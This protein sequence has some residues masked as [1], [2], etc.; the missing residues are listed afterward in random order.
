MSTVFLLGFNFL[1]GCNSSEDYLGG[2]KISEGKIV[3]TLSYPQFAD[4]NIF[5]SMFPSEMNFK[6]KDNNTRN[7]LKTKMAIFSTSLL[8]NNKEKKAT[9]LVKIA[10]KYSG[11][12]MNSKEIM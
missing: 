4:D 6:F 3:Y 8:V 2:K 12:E 10:N 11:L 5:I 7:E 1:V 9:H